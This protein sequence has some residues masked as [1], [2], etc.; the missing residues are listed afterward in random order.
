[1]VQKGSLVDPER[2]RF[3]FEHPQAL[4]AEEIAEV[5]RLVND[6]IYEDL[7]VAWREMPIADAKELPGLRALFG[8][9]YGDVVRVV[10]VGD[11]LSRE[12]AG[13]RIW[14]ALARLV[15]L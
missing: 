13:A 6:S 5:E 9:K 1:M 4:T 3:D 7:P 2:L 10:E 8:E 14:S 12:C 15:P 11:G